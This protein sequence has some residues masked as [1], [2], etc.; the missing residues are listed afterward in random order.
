MGK[1]LTVLAA[2]AGGFVLGI[3]LAP[4]SGKETRQ[5]VKDKSKEYQLKAQ[6]SLDTI[7]KGASSIKEELVSGGTAIKE[8][9]GDVSGEIVSGAKR[10]ADEA[11]GR[12]RSIKE[13]A[14]DTTDSVKR[15]AR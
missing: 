9:A 2:A 14:D 6:D 10:A 12:A 8:I 15:T 4:K 1:I 11:K 3:L 7:K 13:E 5:D